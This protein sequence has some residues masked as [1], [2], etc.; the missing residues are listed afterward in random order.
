[1]IELLVLGA[2][3]LGIT[4]AI[5]KTNRIDEKFIPL[6]AV[7]VGIVIAVVANMKGSDVIIAGI[8]SGLSATGL[9][10]NTIDKLK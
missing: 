6:T 4:Q 10:E 2:I 5:K 9:Y 8:I 7:G 3:T 1:M